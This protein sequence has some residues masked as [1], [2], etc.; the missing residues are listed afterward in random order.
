M[1]FLRN[2]K[3]ESKYKNIRVEVDGVKF[4]SKAEANR[5]LELKVLEAK[6]LIKDL[7]LQ[8]RFPLIVNTVKICTYV[9]DFQYIQDGITITEDVKGMLT[10]VF[11]IKTKLYAACYPDQPL[12]LVSKRRGTWP[13][14]A[15]AS[16]SRR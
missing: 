2:K 7:K 10:D 15:K 8:P 12:T 5:Y 11:K 4:A 1:W 3:G 13:P 16:R 9:A 14:L 6:G